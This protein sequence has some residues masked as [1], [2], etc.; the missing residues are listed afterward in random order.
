MKS[1]TNYIKIVHNKKTYA[2]VILSSF[3]SNQSIFLSDPRQSFQFGV[4]AHKKGFLEKPHYHFKNTRKINDTQQM[5]VVQK[6]KIKVN[7][8][9]KKNVKFKSS[10]LKKGDA[11]NLIYGTHSLEVLE[12]MQ[13]ISVKQG[14][15]LG[16]KR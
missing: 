2:E 1:I 8:F 11:I 4:L 13:C 9:N 10:I 3:K 5:F 12:N 6:G 7:F 15:F 16:E 14:P